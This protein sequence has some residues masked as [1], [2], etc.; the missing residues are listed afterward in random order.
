MTEGPNKELLHYIF[1]TLLTNHRSLIDE[2][3]FIVLFCRGVKQIRVGAPPQDIPA[4]AALPNKHYLQ[5]I[6]SLG[7]AAMGV[8][9][10]DP[11]GLQ[12]DSG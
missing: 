7:K 9:I 5:R 12:R 11:R 8:P 4:M 6:T 2:L 1:G 10:K 3:V